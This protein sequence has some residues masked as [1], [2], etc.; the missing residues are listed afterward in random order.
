MAQ[1]TIRVSDDLVARVR[2]TASRNATSLNA[3]VAW[4]IDA[5]TD[6]ALAVHT[7]VH[8]DIQGD[9]RAVL[10][11]DDSGLEHS[12]VSRDLTAFSDQ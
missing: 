9:V 4:V 2:S 3:Y 6:P 7:D 10:W 8:G 1:L 5:A 12:D 11:H